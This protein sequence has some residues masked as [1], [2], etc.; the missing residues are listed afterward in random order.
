MASVQLYELVLKQSLGITT[1]VK[2][3]HAPGPSVENERKHECDSGMIICVQIVIYALP[4][5]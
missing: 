2:D 3:G 5:A 4:T 1:R